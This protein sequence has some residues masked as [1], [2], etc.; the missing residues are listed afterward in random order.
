MTAA[1]V[2][3]MDLGRGMPA[4]IEAERSVL[5]TIILDNTAYS[6]LHKLSHRPISRW[7]HTVESTHGW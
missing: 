1:H 5:G 7:I 2:L 3:E 6:E 4:S